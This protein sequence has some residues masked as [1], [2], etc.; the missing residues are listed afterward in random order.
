MVQNNII[1]GFLGR[2]SVPVQMG[3]F[4][5]NSGSIFRYRI[6]FWRSCHMTCSGRSSVG[7]NQRE[8][9]IFSIFPSSR[10]SDSTPDSTFNIC[11]RKTVYDW[12][13]ALWFMI[14]P[15]QEQGD[16]CLLCLWTSGSGHL[17]S[18]CVAMTGH[19]L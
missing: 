19:W 12:R 13:F 14:C 18:D 6:P 2:P 16:V 9:Q 15:P 1:W 4:S 5:R 10:I 17:L 7:G 11:Y 8:T 3:S